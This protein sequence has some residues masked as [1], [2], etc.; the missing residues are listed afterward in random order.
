M[1]SST[2]QYFWYGDSEDEV[3][4]MTNAEF[5]EIPGICDHM[6]PVRRVADARKFTDASTE[7]LSGESAPT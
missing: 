3:D 4:G 6:P 1:P 2:D 5:K 7:E